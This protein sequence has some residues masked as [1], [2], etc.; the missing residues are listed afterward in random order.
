MYNKRI[1]DNTIY[2]HELK[3]RP[4][5]I[6]THPKDYRVMDSFLSQNFQGCLKTMDPASR[7]IKSSTMI[8]PDN[9]Q[10]LLKKNKQT[11]CDIT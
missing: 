8:L 11:A 2:Q 10:K 4:I 5:I 1:I 6:I 9:N 7:K 3:G